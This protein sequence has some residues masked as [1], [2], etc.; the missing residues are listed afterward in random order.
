[1][2][3]PKDS[4]WRFWRRRVQYAEPGM[5]DSLPSS[6]QPDP[7]IALVQTTSQTDL[8]EQLRVAVDMAASRSAD[9]MEVLRLAVR[10]YTVALRSA[11]ST[12]EAVL[13]NLKRV[14]HEM[15][16]P[17]IGSYG[18]DFRGR[19]L[20]EQINTWCIQEYFKEKTA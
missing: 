13:I 3:S 17:Y 16:L 15:S 4:N 14:V 18:G 1:M 11:G 8:R 20:P 9:S 2:L 5:A 19:S 10:D 7:T 6:Q 12:P